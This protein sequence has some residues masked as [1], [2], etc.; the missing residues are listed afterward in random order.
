MR[1]PLS[2]FLFFGVLLLAHRLTAQ[3]FYA[4]DFIENKG[5]WKE[6]F[7]YKSTIGDG[8]VFIQRQGYTILKNNP[9]DYNAVLEYMHGH[10]TNA[11]V[12][13]KINADMQEGQPEKDPK[14]IPILNSHAYSVIFKGSSGNSA[15]QNEKFTGET[16]NYFLGDDPSKWQKNVKSFGSIVQKDLYPGI[17][18]RYYSSGDKM[19]Y[20][21][22]VKAGGDPSRIVMQYDGVDKLSIK[23]GHLVIGTSVGE[24]KE[25][26][27]YAFQIIGGLKKEVEC[28]YEITGKTVQFKIKSYDKSAPLII[29][30]ILVF[31]TYTGSRISNWG[32]T[33]APGPDGSLYAGGIAFG[34]GYPISIG[35]F[36]S[37]FS[38]GVGQGSISGID[39][40]LTRFSADGRARIFS[41]Y[42][43]GSGDEFP[44]SIFVDPAGNP[45]ILGRT[46]SQN[47]PTLNNNKVGPLGATDIFVTKLSA[48]G[49]KLLGG[50]LVGGRGIDGANIDPSISPGPKSILYNY[51]DNARSEVILDKSNN[52]YIA[53]CSQSSDFPLKNSFQ[54]YAGLQ[55]GIVMKFSPDLS[56]LFF[57]SYMGGDDDDAS[58][59]LAL[60]PINNDIYVGGATRS[61]NF[62]GNKSGTIGTSFQGNIDGFVSVLNNNGVPVRS[63]F[64]GTNAIDIV[65]GI[66]FDA[67]GFPYVMGISLGAWPVKN[68]T[69]RDPGSKQFISKL[70]P[71][72]SDYVYSTVYG[73]GAAVPNISPV[74]FLVDRCE[75]VYVSGWGGKLNLCYNGAFDQKT[76]GT[77]GLKTVGGPIQSY[78]DNKDFYFFVLQKDA[79]SQLYGSFYGQQGGEGDHVDGGTSRF[80]NKGAIYQ[81]VCANCGGTS[82]CSKD[83]IR[84]PLII[85]PGVVGPTNGSLG[86]GSAGECNLAAFKINFE[87]DGIKAGAQTAIDGVV[88]DT[89]GCVPL[90]VDFTDSIDMGK[91][92]EWDFGDGS[93]GFSGTTPIVSHTYT[94][95]GNFRAR[96]I[97][98]DNDR[99][100]PRDTSYVTIR[101]RTDKAIIAAV[102]NKLPPCEGFNVRFT[103]NSIAPLGRVF[104]DTSF[105]WDFGDN[106]PRVKMGKSS[107]DHTFPAAGSYK[108]KLFLNDTTYCNAFD[109]EE[110]TMYLSP[111]VKANFTTPLIGCLPHKAEFKNTSVAGQT[112]IWN[113]GDGT[114]NYT[115]ANPPVHLYNRLGDY[116]IRLIANDPATCNFTDTFSYTISVKPS[117]VAGFTFSPD[118][119]EVNT[120]TQFSNGSSGASTFRWFFGDGDTSIQVNPVHLYP[121]SDLFNACLV[122][123]N[124]FGCTDTVCSNIQALVKAIV[125]VPNAFTPNGDG[126][127]DK[128]FVRGFGIEQMNFRIYNR[129]GQLVFESGSPYFGWDGKFKGELQ[130]MDSY[131]YTLLVLF[132]DGTQ[133][134]KKGDITLLR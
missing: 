72:L 63:T 3:S 31:S 27:P 80:D 95:P 45:V 10:Q 93:T 118:P 114:P 98:I 85:T 91:S 37:S 44:H 30:P 41:T 65:Y 130:P 119:P 82:I 97:S 39:I 96:L 49:T 56:T 133:A 42:L 113:F 19:K 29:D 38:G 100:I 117:P 52:I 62:Q 78:T 105:V 23:D 51:G 18:I 6:D 121:K 132:S 88:Y 115:G 67:K 40:S 4:I 77:N 126:K 107:I 81:A 76:V 20:D 104:S 129:W 99:C 83:P 34:S 2:I 108:I 116:V 103:N 55:D 86:S 13:V 73:T 26:P 21:F 47:F 92:Y 64:L 5:Q 106:S 57:S 61:N 33:A 123:Y 69:Y 74:A 79:T 17:D 60:N 14:S 120:P 1:I 109:T 89:A 28:R 66:Q 111:L 70:K 112:F 110:F 54:N 15:F 125:D 11:K 46:T 25:L 8:T 36:Q 7:R 22:T 58:F 90:K 71:D 16:A 50:V 131:A 84:R 68:A 124:Q 35:A 134:S 48:D 102:G 122:A 32:F 101:V 87:F 24:S 75:N 9:A 53:S 128:V 12:P 94:R 59:V 43:G 127:N